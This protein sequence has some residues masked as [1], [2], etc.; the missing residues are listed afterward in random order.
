MSETLRLFG[1]DE[2]S[3]LQSSAWLSSIFFL[4]LRRDARK[5]GWGK[6]VREGWRERE[7]ETEGGMVWG[8]RM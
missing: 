3:S 6:A 1:R 2:Q 5:G 8:M 7:R 4:F